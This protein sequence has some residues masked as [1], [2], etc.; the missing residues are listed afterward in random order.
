MHLFKKEDY[1]NITEYL[2]KVESSNISEEC[3]K[4]LKLAEKVQYYAIYKDRNNFQE[5]SDSLNEIDSCLL[6][7]MSHDHTE[8]LGIFCDRIVPSPQILKEILIMGLE[9]WR[10]RPEKYNCGSNENG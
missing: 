2:T 5:S 7:A 9:E 6:H 1:E 3:T 10:R 4:P 8:I